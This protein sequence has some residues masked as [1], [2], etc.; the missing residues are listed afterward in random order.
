[1]TDC[2]QESTGKPDTGVATLWFSCNYGAILTTYA[3]YEVL[4][5]M[6]KRPVLLD[7]APVGG[8][9]PFMDEENI[10]RRFMREHGIPYTAPLRS[11]ADYNAL[12][13]GPDT[14]VVGSDQVWRWRYTGCY[15]LAYFLDYVQG[16]KRK[17]AY[18][19]SFGIDSEERPVESVRRASF[20]LHAFDGVSV[21]EK[22][23]VDILREQ[24][25]VE[26][27]W[28]L[29]PVFLCGK[30]VY[31][32]LCSSAEAAGAPYVLSYVLEPD[33]VIRHHIA[34]VTGVRGL[35]AV[36]MVDAQ[37]DFAEMQRR[38]G[39]GELAQGVSVEQWVQNIR[40]CDF[41]ITD[42]F[43]GVCYALMFNRPFLCVAP[44]QRGRARFD[45]L[46]GLVGLER[47]MLSPDYTQAEWKAAMA[48]IDWAH[49]NAVLEREREK[50]LAWLADALQAP[51]PAWRV[52]LG[53]LVYS[54]LYAGMSERARTS[55]QEAELQYHLRMFR[56]GLLPRLL[57][58]RRLW[59]RALA[60]VTSG[61][62]RKR[63]AA[64]L[65]ELRAVEAHL[66]RR[67]AGLADMN[68]R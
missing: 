14:F 11:D 4:R 27:E 9:G 12:N 39:P 25:G 53:D 18:S 24:Y 48:P 65:R 66:A 2:V 7:Y 10:S 5:G 56:T 49:V 22:S 23:G 62:V 50:A 47:C 51:R 54:K 8:H 20:C 41:F 57:L 30:D 68:K 42:S 31:E 40:G 33:E 35:R 63:H 46:L 34:A 6:G 21:R 55:R 64:R 13:D 37:R 32:R 15:G 36:N 28:L 38:F 45:S 19:S 43:H 61:S 60:C 58:L 29:D 67:E 52:A 17:L 59:H 3:L 44:P 1:M 16:C 26:A